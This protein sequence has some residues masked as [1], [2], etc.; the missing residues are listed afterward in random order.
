MDA[1]CFR[2]LTGLPCSVVARAVGDVSSG[3]GSPYADATRHGAGY[4][5]YELTYEPVRG[6]TETQ[7]EHQRFPPRTPTCSRATG[8]GY[9]H[10]LTTI[11]VVVVDREL[12]GTRSI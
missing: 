8:T 10:R 1:P 2:F 4:W 6:E 9:L 5:R 3:Q 7:K 11:P 12:T